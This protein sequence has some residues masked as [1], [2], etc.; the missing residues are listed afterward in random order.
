[1][2]RIKGAV[3]VNMDINT[4]DLNILTAFMQPGGFLMFEA[5]VKHAGSAVYDGDIGDEL[6]LNAYVSADNFARI[7]DCSIYRDVLRYFGDL[8]LAYVGVDNEEIMDEINSFSLELNQWERDVSFFGFVDEGSNSINERARNISGE[9][10]S[11]SY[12]V[13]RERKVFWTRYDQLTHALRLCSRQIIVE[14]LR[15]HVAHYAPTLLD[16]GG[17]EPDFADPTDYLEGFSDPTP[18]Q[19]G[20]AYDAFREAR[21]G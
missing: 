15:K 16:V 3:S 21:K 20:R 11:A 19:F 14:G 5:V 17:H 12:R 2:V 10:C 18:D 6:Q 1:M 4:E 13:A 8:T 9:R 7:G